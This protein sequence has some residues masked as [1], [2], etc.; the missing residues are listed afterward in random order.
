[1]LKELWFCCCDIAIKVHLCLRSY[2]FV[3]GRVEHKTNCVFMVK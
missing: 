3:V 1:V 2:G